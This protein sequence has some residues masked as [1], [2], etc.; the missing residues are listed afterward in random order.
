MFGDADV[1][2][3]ERVDEFPQQGFFRVLGAGGADAFVLFF[4]EG[5]VVECLI[6]CLAPVFLAHF[7]VQVSIG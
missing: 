5:G 3:G 1:G 7:F 4:D 6:I 2:V